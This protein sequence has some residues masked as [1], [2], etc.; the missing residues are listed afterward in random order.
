[1]TLPAFATERR[2]PP[3]SIDMSCHLGAQQQTRRTPQRLSNDGTDDERTDGRTP[4]HYTDLAP[5]TMPAVSL[6]H[7]MLMITWS[8]YVKQEVFR[9]LSDRL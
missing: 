8:V 4:G 6:T 2:R 3:L 7:C 9:L 1:M 5:H